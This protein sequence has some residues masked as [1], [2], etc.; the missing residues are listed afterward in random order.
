[1]AVCFG[2]LITRAIRRIL[3]TIL[4][5]IL[6]E[7]YTEHHQL[8]M[9]CIK[10]PTLPML[11]SISA[12][13]EFYIQIIMVLHGIPCMILDILSNGWQTIRITLT[14]CMPALCTAHRE[15]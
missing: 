6:M 9:I 11:P 14:E 15:E 4:S 1:M 12:R 10:V 2:I 8:F 3:C 7:F 13:V 5:N